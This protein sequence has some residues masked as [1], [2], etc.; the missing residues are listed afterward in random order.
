MG[1]GGGADGGRG[2]RHHWE[3]NFVHYSEVSLTWGFWYISGRHGM[4]NWAVEHNVGVF[5]ELFLAVRW[6]GM[7][8]RG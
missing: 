1:V 3:Q 4:C 2:S 5:S 7:L 8:C 6:Q